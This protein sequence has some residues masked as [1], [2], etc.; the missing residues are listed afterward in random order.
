V[1]ILLLL[2]IVPSALSNDTITVNLMT[3]P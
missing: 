3:A 1:D 2:D